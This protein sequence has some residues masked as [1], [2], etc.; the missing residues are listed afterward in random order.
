[1]KKNELAKKSRKLFSAILAGAM[2]TTS[3]IPESFV[4][5]AQAEDVQGFGD[6]ESMG[7]ESTPDPVTGDG[8]DGENQEVSDFQGVAD[9]QNGNAIVNMEEGFTDEI[10][11]FSSNGS[12]IPVES[13]FQSQASVEEL[14]ERINTLPTVEEFQNLADGTTVEGSTLNQAQTDVYAEACSKTSI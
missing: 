14:Q 4:W 11:S 10:A 7:F 8:E 9:I 1:M 5:A 13:G 6:S 12:D 2:L 3:V